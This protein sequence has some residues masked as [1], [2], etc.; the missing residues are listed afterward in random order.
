MTSRTIA[1]RATHAGSAAAALTLAAV[2]ALMAGAKTAK[3]W[4]SRQPTTR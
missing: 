4:D 1:A 3:A 2:I